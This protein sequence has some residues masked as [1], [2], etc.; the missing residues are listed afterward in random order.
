MLPLLGVDSTSQISSATISR[1][2]G[3]QLIPFLFALVA[4]LGVF[5]R[6]RIAVIIPVVLIF[7]AQLG[8]QLGAK[9]DPMVPILPALCLIL[10]CIP[11]RSKIWG[12]KEK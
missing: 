4:V 1:W 9:M 6:T 7:M 5:K 11:G 2:F 10:A 12:S 3:R 8:A